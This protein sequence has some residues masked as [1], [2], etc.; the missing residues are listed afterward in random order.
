MRQLLPGSP[1]MPGRA[2]AFCHRSHGGGLARCLGPG[3]VVSGGRPLRRE[4]VCS[5]EVGGPAH[6]R[7]LSCGDFVPAVRAA[8]VACR[9]AWRERCEHVKAGAAVETA[10]L[11]V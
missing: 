11:V 8:G 9:G 5:L 2:T 4:A 3:L 1:G 10:C 6:V 7:C